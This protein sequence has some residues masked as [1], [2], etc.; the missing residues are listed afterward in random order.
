VAG[1]FVF[2]VGCAGSKA[3]DGSGAGS[4][5][6]SAVG[7]RDAGVV[8]VTLPVP[9]AAGADGAA[10]TAVPSPLITDWPITWTDERTE[11]MLAYRR[12]HSDASATDLAIAPEVIVLHYTA[13]SSA[14]GTK[15]Y[16]DRTRIETARARL[17]DAGAV[18][19][20]S[21]FLVDR[22]GTIFRLQPETR[23]G[24]HCIG[25]NHI[26]IGVENVGDEKKYPLTDAQIEANV[27]LV[28]YLAAKYPITMLVGH[29]EAD[30]LEGTRYFVEL[31][32][33]YRNDKPDPGARFMAAVRAKLTDLTTVS[34]PPTP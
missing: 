17:K 34:G 7:Q 32:P 21:Q 24:R 1:A 25:L 18:N 15:R 13:G 5:T 30:R 3:G 6:G 4:A 23:M 19:V 14:K 2:L 20:S 27:A 29:D 8:A 22:D 16:F 11:L 26:A 10:R 12:A 28:R 33:T 9:D 31:D